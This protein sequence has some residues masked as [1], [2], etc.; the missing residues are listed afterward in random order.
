MHKKKRA[1]GVVVA[2]VVPI[3]QRKLRFSFEYLDLN[4]PRFQ[5][6]ECDKE[7]YDALLRE[8]LKYQQYS[9]DMF[10]QSDPRERRHPIYFPGTHE[11]EGFNVDPNIEELWTDSAWQFGLSHPDKRQVGWRVHG[12][13]AEETFYIVWLDPNH[14]LDGTPYITH[15]DS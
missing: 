6:E 1:T 9:V 2:P 12:F 15:P 8:I 4:H 11:P 14:K 13:L 3:D 10:T 7:F 5:I